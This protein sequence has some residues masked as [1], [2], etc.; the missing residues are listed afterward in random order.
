[1]AFD[2]SSTAQNPCKKQFCRAHQ[3]VMQNRCKKQHI[4]QPHFFPVPSNR[5]R[6]A[7]NGAK[8]CRKQHV[9]RFHVSY[10]PRFLSRPSKS[11][12][13]PLQKTAHRA[14]ALFSCAARP[15]AD[16]TPSSRTVTKPLQKTLFPAVHPPYMSSATLSLISRRTPNAS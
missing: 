15:S 5:F 11:D 6:N 13:K 3:K 12:A 2:R 8:P 16:R 4:A 1:M 10:A 14:T 7:M 9:A